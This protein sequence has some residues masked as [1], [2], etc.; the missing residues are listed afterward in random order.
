MYNR[1]TETNI[2]EVCEFI[3]KVKCIFMLNFHVIIIFLFVLYLF[4]NNN[5]IF[6]FMQATLKQK[7]YFKPTQ[8]WLVYCVYECVYVCYS[9]SYY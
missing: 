3:D 5:Y 9:V 1:I 4:I 8:T 7:C 6:Y 2:H